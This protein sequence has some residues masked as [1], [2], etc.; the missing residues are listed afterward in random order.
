LKVLFGRSGGGVPEMRTNAD[1]LVMVSV[2]GR[3]SSPT[4]AEI[5]YRVGSSGNPVIL[6]GTG[7]ITYNIKVG[8]PATGWVADHVE[9]GVSVKNPAP[10]EGTRSANAALN[11][12]SC[13]GNTA[14]VITGDAKGAKG[15]VTGKH[16]GIEHVLMDFDDRTLDKL[17]IGD[18]V[19]VKAC[20]TGL[21]M[22]DA[23]TVKIMNLDP[24][25]LGRL[26]L[27]VSKGRLEVGVSHV[28]PAAMMGSGIGKA[29]AHSGDYDIQLLDKKSVAKYGLENIRLGDIV[30]IKDADNTFGRMYRKG[31]VTIGV[32]VHSDC[33]L[34]GHGPGVTTIMTHSRGGIVPS[35]DKDANIAKLL[36]IGIHRT[37]T[38]GGR[39]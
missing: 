25:L 28:V 19:L 3:V 24:G 15:V 27:V 6:P 10:R 18:S 2:T 13:I 12:L 11:I 31:A 33:V 26:N 39:K 8:H 34:S 7:G 36:G 5:G 4:M 32:V 16:G 37:K 14:T 29:H 9:P 30:A 1:K 21:H 17:A 35:I 20:G 38:K 22:D 23:E